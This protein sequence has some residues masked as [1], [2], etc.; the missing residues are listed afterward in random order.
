[1][2]KLPIAG[3]IA[4]LFPAS[5]IHAETA[6]SGLPF[7]SELDRIV[8]T[9]TLNERS[10]QDVANE[11]SVI[12]AAEI[13]RRQSQSV[14][15]V[16]R[17]EPG[18]SSSSSA[19]GGGR[20]GQGGI[21][22]RGLG[23]N[24]VRIELDGVAIPDSFEIGSFSSAGRDVVDVD[25]LKRVEI[26]RGASSSLYGSDA[27]A[28]VVS[29][30]TKD[31]VDYLGKEGGH[32]L[33][34]KLLYDSANR[35]SALTG[36]WAGGSEKDGMVVVATHRVGSAYN[37][38]GDIDSADSSRTR[39]NPQDTRSDALL[40]KYVHT[41]PS[42]RVDRLTLDGE[43]GTVETDVLTSR[44]VN[45]LTGALTS[46]LF[47]DDSRER[48]R[49]GFGQSY[50]LSTG[51]AD[52]LEW[53]AN[54]QRSSATQDTLED[55]ATLT[56]QGLVNPNRRFR[57]FEF[58]QR[59]IGAEMTARKALQSTSV[60]HAITYGLDVSR[61]RSEEI[62]D[63]WQLNL[64][65]GQLSNVVMP[66]IFP[67]RDFPIS[68]STNA[69]AFVQDELT[70]ADGKV[71]L[72][73]ALR[74]DHYRLD[75]KPDATFE[76]DNPGV[77]TAG[78]NST[79]WSPKFGAIWRFNETLSM[80]AQYAHGFR[81]PPY[82]DVNLGFTNLAFGYTSLPN[83]EL[84]PESSNGLEVGL[85]AN[86]S[87]GWFSVSAYENRYRDFIESMSF[88]GMDPQT[89]LMLFQSVNLGKVRIRGSEARFGIDLG[90]LSGSLDRWQIK[91]SLASARGDDQSADE[92]LVSVDPATAVLGLAYSGNDWG[93]ELLARMVARKDRLPLPS[94]SPDPN[95]PPATPLFEAPGHATLD[96]Y[97]NWKP[98]RQLEL[99]GALTNIDNRR[100]WDWGTV[101]GFTER[102]NIDLYSAPGRAIRLGMRTTF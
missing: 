55:R 11:V 96:L 86:G 28:G 12:E 80:F 85:R 101:A 69:A 23:G 50:S 34:G 53:N 7:L 79:S 48:V 65:T 38:R 57:R 5:V 78:L 93:A 6:T 27:L 37:N 54:A 17:Y 2:S 58:E 98:L 26:V 83:P 13:D 60:E 52:S 36:S 32:Y 56:D 14:A 25:A 90:A 40:A 4:S 30:V 74:V 22:I 99:F 82:N 75:P 102:A 73:P 81:A 15:D 63:G 31:P 77:E 45:P 29:Y 24:R 20:F 94:T 71:S 49:L 97:V 43:Y 42:G 92:P 89:G 35:G 59:V 46:S 70:L 9:A 3:A 16:L 95:Q 87:L 19:I 44:T 1:M 51:L 88:V 91:G 61:T 10:Q 47:G 100:Y 21:S 33:A 41:A 62:R 68:E 64:T 67:V 8:V 72:I 18:V 84:E 39:P 76:D 66:D